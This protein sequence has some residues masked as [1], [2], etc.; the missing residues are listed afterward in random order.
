IF[1]TGQSVDA[2]AGSTTVQRL[3]DD[4]FINTM[5]AVDAEALDEGRRPMWWMHP[6]QMLRAMSIR[7]GGQ[8]L[9][10]TPVE[11]PGRGIVSIKGFPVVTSGVCPSTNTPGSKVAAFGDGDAQAVGVRK[12]FTLESS[13]HFKWN[14]LQ[15]TFRGFGRARTETLAAT[16]FAY[17][18]TAAQ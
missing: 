8:S 16:R 6:T 13:K 11:Q 5:L 2:S 17:L 15:R 18:K 10:K 1:V 14:T 9:L 4:D 3:T 12:D 7:V